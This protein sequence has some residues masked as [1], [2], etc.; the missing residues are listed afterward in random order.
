[1]FVIFAQAS[2]SAASKRTKTRMVPV[3]SAILNLQA[4][5]KSYQ[6]GDFEAAGQVFDSLIQR[7]A[8]HDSQL[9]FL[10]LYYGIRSR[11]ETGRIS[12]ADSLYEASSH[13]VPARQR[14]DLEATLG[15]DVSAG[16]EQ[17]FS[18]KPRLI[19]FK[20]GV[21]LPL[22]GKFAEF[23]KAILEGIQLAVQEYNQG[24]PGRN[25][26]LLETLDDESNPVLAA[27]RGRILAADSLVAAIIGSYENETSLALSLVAASTGIPL[28]CPTADAPGLDNLGPLVHVL[29][30]TESEMAAKLAEFS[31]NELGLQTFSVFAPDDE[32]GNLLAGSFVSGVRAAGGAMVFDQRYTSQTSTFE[33]Q[34]NLLRRYLPDAL[35][36]PA[37]SNEITQ[38][39]SQVFYFGLGPLRL[40]GTEQWNSERVI[41]LGG[42]YVDRAVFASPFYENGEGLRWNEFKDLYERTYRKPVNHYSAL[43]YDALGL[44]VRAAGQ[45]PADRRL[46]A[47]NLNLTD[48]YQGAVGIYTIEA[49]GKVKRKAFILEL[50]EGNVVPARAEGPEMNQEKTAPDSS[51][52]T[53]APPGSR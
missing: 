33:N 23:G 9:V 7:A 17:L 50:S 24:Q 35:Y 4:G 46:L 45:F 48:T 12:S 44:F 40:L 27:T 29:N 21:V 39:A 19:A 51:S 6:I 1:M 30:R 37:E 49:D 16:K 47:E 52:P 53:I 8:P 26:V 36:L 22:S 14:L 28:I 34:M 2:C 32:R 31:V 41:R 15:R 13:L 11:L 25:K 42:K 38:L 5:L 10:A 43:G 20:L 3:E 18:N